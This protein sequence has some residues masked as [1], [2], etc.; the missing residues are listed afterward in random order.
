M[1]NFILADTSELFRM[2]ALFM[3][4][5]HLACWDKLIAVVRLISAFW[6]QKHLI[7]TF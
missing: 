4:I 7:P 5:F 6:A 2:Y 3:K 1:K